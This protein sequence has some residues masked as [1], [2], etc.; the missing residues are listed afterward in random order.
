[1]ALKEG[2]ILVTAFC[3][4]SATRGVAQSEL[5]TVPVHARW[6]LPQVP[7]PRVPVTLGHG[8]ICFSQSLSFPVGEFVSDVL[9]VPEKCQFFHKERMEV[10]ENHQHWHTV[11]REVKR[12]AGRS[13]AAALRKEG[14]TSPPLTTC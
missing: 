14:G 4:P 5:E 11:V 8:L 9:L 2:G 6:A 13:G 1:M 7:A 10:C 12:W 3:L